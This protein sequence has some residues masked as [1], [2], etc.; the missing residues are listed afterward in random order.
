[1]ENFLMM[2]F[3]IKMFYAF[4][5][6][7]FVFLVARL[8]DKQIGINFKEEF[9]K[10]KKDEKALGIYFGFRLVAISIIISSFF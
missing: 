1:M 5:T 6:L 3:V 10:V 4:L 7:V 9:S 2:D 8:S